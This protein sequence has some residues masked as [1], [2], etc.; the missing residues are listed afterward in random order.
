MN[1]CLFCDSTALTREHVWPDWIVR[2]FDK[3][4]PKTMWSATHYNKPD[5]T[6]AEWNSRSLTFKTRVVCEPCNGGWMSDVE[7][8]CKSI[9]HPLMVSPHPGA[10][11]ALDHARSPSGPRCALLRSSL[12]TPVPRRACRTRSSKNSRSGCPSW[13]VRWAATPS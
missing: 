1:R 13:P 2:I 6:K 11:N 5:G 12:F 9:V 3:H 10:I 7:T 8:H 4:V